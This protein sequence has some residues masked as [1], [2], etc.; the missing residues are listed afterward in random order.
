MTTL[1]GALS[2]ACA[3]AALW[4]ASADAQPATA[5]VLH[6]FGFGFDPYAG[7]VRD[8]AGNFY[9][10]TS[11]GGIGC[12]FIGCGVVYKLD[13]AGNY[14][15]LYEFTGGSD[16][17]SPFAGVVL[18]SDGNLY[19]T[20]TYGGA[21]L[22]G[23]VYK[24]DKAGSQTVLHTF[25]GGA[26]GGAPRSGVVRDRKGILYGTTFS[27]GSGHGV[28][29][30]VDQKGQE[31]V[32]YTFTGGADGG[33]PYAGLILD[34]EGNLY[35]TTVAGGSGAGVVYKLNP[36]GQETVLY[37]FTG[38]AD[39]SGPYAS[40]I[41]DSAG[42][43]YGTTVGGGVFTAP[44][45]YGCGVVF[46]LDTRGQETALYRFTGWADGGSPYGGVILDS[47]G[48]LYGTTLYG[49]RRPDGNFR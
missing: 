3:L 17:G 48:N 49:G 41:R 13:T 44:C 46:K 1:Q 24:L 7:L 31:K 32:L 42:N 25:T 9:G 22:N 11:A 37:T 15:V 40:V 16:G 8:S 20:T 35:G 5:I 26:D 36:D 28:V 2:R 43:L 29:Y 21:N 19:G 47:V 6:S 39:G 4:I 45:T 27:G 18:D 33:L 30:R 34:S 14:T 23:V 10:T 38:G 12:N